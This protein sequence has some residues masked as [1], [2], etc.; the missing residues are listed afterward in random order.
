[1]DMQ[2]RLVLKD[3]LGSCF[4]LPTLEWQRCQ[5]RLLEPD[6]DRELR[7]LITQ[8]ESL[9]ARIAKTCYPRPITTPADIFR[10]LVALDEEFDSLHI[11]FKEHTLSVTTE[12]IELRGP[13]ER[14]N[15]SSPRAGDL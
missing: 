7:R 1:M 10:E 2:E 12:A 4:T 13:A 15:V 14:R 8:L 6:T 9:A 11:D 5:E 3:Q